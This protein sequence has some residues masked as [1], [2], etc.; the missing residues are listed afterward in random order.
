[1]P[2]GALAK[3]DGGEV[4]SEYVHGAAQRREPGGNEGGAMVGAKRSL[5]NGEI[6]LKFAGVDIG[7]AR[8]DGVAQGF[9][10][11]QHDESR[12]QPRIDAGERAPIGFIL[13][14]GVLIARSIREGLQLR[15]RADQPA[16]DGKLPAEMVNLGQ[17]IAQRDLALAAQGEFERIG[18]DVRIAVA[19]AADPGS[20][21]EETVDPFAGKVIFEFGVKAR[22]LL[23]EGHLVEAQRVLDLVADGE[24]RITQ[25]P[26]LPQLRDAG[27][28]QEF[29]LFPRA[30]ALEP[31]MRK[32]QLRDRPL[33]F[34]QASALNLG[35]M[36]GE[37]GRNHAA[38]QRLGDRPRRN[39][40]GGQALERL[41]EGA[42]LMIL[43]LF[44]GQRR[45]GADIVPVFG[46]IGEMGEIAER[47]DDRHGLFRSEAAQQ[48]IELVARLRIGAALKGDAEAPDGLDPRKCFLAFLFA[49]GI[50]EQLAEQTDVVD[51]RTLNEGGAC[52]LCRVERFRH[53]CLFGVEL[54]GWRAGGGRV[55]GG[56]LGSPAGFLNAAAARRL[57]A[58]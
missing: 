4:E 38:L 49:N 20:H 23:Q 41:G 19:V 9:A 27:A 52:R 2:V 1:M 18:V 56:S 48:R 53:Q 33:G 54:A 28:Q 15:R 5:D 26:R 8:R 12:R 22:N 7:F 43:R 21:A 39:R 30:R 35:R 57:S 42:A 17:V 25:Q 51:Q 46:D 32:Q 45:A 47:A 58:S 31:F 6:G 13:A 40:R 11:G 37:H 55:H 50:A 3:V 16:R 29:V 44:L 14:M 24:A 34:E 36:R 10:A